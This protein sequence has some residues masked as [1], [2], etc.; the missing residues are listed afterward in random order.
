MKAWVLGAV[1]IFTVCIAGCGGNS[2]TVAVTVTG[3]TAANTGFPVP[4]NGSVQLGAT[5]SGITAQTVY[6]QVCLHVSAVTNS[7]GQPTTSPTDCTPAYSTSQCTVPTV[8]SPLTGYGTITPNGL[9]TAPA[10]VPSPNIAYAV[11]TSCVNPTYF[12]TFELIVKSGYSVSITPTT[13]TIATGQTYQFNA[14][15]KGPGTSGVNWAVCTS[16]AGSSGLTCGGPGLGMITGSGAYTA[17]ATIPPSAVTIQAT[18]VTDSTQTATATVDVVAAAA[19]TITS[20]DPTVAA[21]GSAQQDVYLTGTNFLST[22][23]VFVG[24]NGQTP[25]AVPTTILSTTLIRATIPEAALAQAGPLDVT[26]QTP[27][28]SLTAPVAKTMTLFATRPALI[29]SLPDSVSQSTGGTVTLSGGFFSGANVNLTTPSFNGAPLSTWS[30]KSS[31]QLSFTLPGTAVPTAGLYPI[32]LKNAGV[33]PVAGMNLA[34]TPDAN[35]IASGPVAGPIA[36]GTEPTSVAIDKAD[37]IAVIANTGSNNVTLVNLTSRTAVG[38][39]AVGIQPTGIAVDDQL[40]DPVALVVNSTDQTVTA[41]DLTTQLTTTISVSIS[42]GSNPSLPVAIGVNPMTAQPVPGVTPV[43]HRALVAYS[44]S[45]QATVLDVSDVSGKPVL[46]IVQTIGSSAILSY[47]TGPHP[48]VGIDPRLNWAIVT[49]GGSGTIGIVDLGRDPVPGVDVGRVPQVIAALSV[50]T[51]VQGIGVNSETHQVLLSDP[52][53]GTLTTFSPLNDSVTTVTNPCSGPPPCTGAPFSAI[54]YSAAAVNPLENVGVAVASGNAV[55]VNLESGVVLKSVTGLAS[56]SAAQAVAV[57]PVTNQA[58]VVNSD[59]NSVSILSLGGALNPMQIVETSPATTFTSSAPLTLTVTGNFL[60]GSQVRLDQQIL[61]TTGCA[62]GPC[63]QLTAIVPAASLGSAARYTLDVV[64]P[65]QQVSNVEDFTVIQTI[66][67]GTTP[68]GVAIDTDRDL[69]VV[70]NSGSNNASLVSLA[71]GTNS[72]LSL[73]PVGELP[74]SPVQV[75]SAP[76]GVAVLSRAGIAVVANNGSND[77]TAIDETGVNTPATVTLCGA[78]CVGPTGVAVNPDT[79]TAAVTSADYGPTF[80]SSILSTFPLTSAASSASGSITVDQGAVAVAID[81]YLDYAAVATASSA[82]SV[83]IIDL[84][85]DSKVGGITGVLQNPSGVIFDP[86]NQVFLTADSLQNAVSIIDPATF[87][88]TSVAVG[89]APTSLDYNYQTST[90][91]TVNGPSR[92]MSIMAYL[93]PPT[94]SA[95]TCIGPQ[96]RSVLGIGGSQTSSTVLGANAV[97]IDP[98]LNLAAVVDPDNNRLLLIPLPR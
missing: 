93:C 63:R 77:A 33:I 47:S 62:S 89:I 81:P 14:T 24:P 90:L 34:V 21:A 96:V 50:S 32:V 60:Q 43:V 80:T 56:S 68:V 82:S 75:G 16:V 1:I 73:G 15:V 70:T 88:P 36:V 7:T 5:V 86:V 65:A 58:V 91:V 67:V 10:N 53:S 13:A 48:S 87:L 92:T 3:P 30:L 72:P 27:D 54:G 40:P 49:P 71:E 57:D 59:S 45:N 8:S 55:V 95:P 76:A 18:L 26:V 20:M 78:N 61:A 85:T 4:V 9:Y 6:W 79:S 42:A 29:A 51:T 44:S 38:N 97:A 83:D 2:T 22:E 11:A 23:D 28:G 74:Y 25:V 19:P 17:P 46:S 66:P 84:A 12:G 98:K 31:R 52:T 37:G 69:A 94:G 39:I 35:L 41:I 64:G